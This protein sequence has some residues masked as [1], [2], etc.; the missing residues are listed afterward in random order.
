MDFSLRAK[1]KL[2]DVSIYSFL[3]LHYSMLMAHGFDPG[4][5]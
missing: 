4:C 2:V 1:V 5:F 3:S